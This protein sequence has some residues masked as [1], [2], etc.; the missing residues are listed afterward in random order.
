MTP[1]IE[2]TDL[3][4]KYPSGVV[5]LSSINISVEWG[6]RV[7]VIGPNGAG[8]STLLKLLAGKTLT[9]SGSIKL[10]GKD[11]FQFSANNIAT[12]LGTE[13]ILNSTIKRDM[14][15]QTLI[16][17]VG[18]NKSPERRDKLVEILD[19]DLDWNMNQISDGQRR[20]VQ[21]L[22]KLFGLWKVLLLDEVTVDLD[23]LVRLRLLNFLKQETETRECC[24][25]HATHIFDGL[26]SLDFPTHVM[27]LSS[28]KIVRQL[29]FNRDIEF[30][31]VVADNKYGDIEDI[32]DSKKHLELLDDHRS[33]VQIHSVHSI[34]P[35]AL[36]WLTT[37]YI[38]K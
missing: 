19:I 16:E 7:I 6:S 18:V 23:V 31:K 21:L 20:R 37:D 33:T 9:R 17:S 28:G 30:T 25:V 12:Y 22:L 14:P 13:W 38:S 11:P 1:A 35:L 15:V 34:H 3:S 8:K 5:G 26:A 36:Q 27:H 2:V 4:Y 32:L 29:D 24:I 10:N